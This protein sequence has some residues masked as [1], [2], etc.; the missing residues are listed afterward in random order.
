MLKYDIRSGVK[1]IKTKTIMT[2]SGAAVG[3][4]GLVV[5]IAMPLAVKAAPPAFQ[6]QP[7]EFVGVAGD[8][9]PAPGVD[10]VTAKWDNTTGNPTP[11]ILLQKLGAT[12]NCAAAGV[13]IITPLEGGPVGALT[14]LNFDY[15]DGGHCGAGAPRFD[16]QTDTGTAQALGCNTVLG[17]RTP[18][19]TTGWTHVEFNATDIAASLATWAPGATTL[20]DLYII[21]DEGS[22]TGPDFTGTI[23]IDNISVN[24]QV[25][26]S[27]TSPLT[28]DDC[29]NGGWQNTNFS[30]AFKN[31]GQCVSWVEHNVNGH[32][33]PHVH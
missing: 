7:F 21:F 8:C 9:G 26:G 18:I 24:N 31:Q 32:G 17:T 22:D 11:S 27:P 23:N 19:G 13:D 6:L 5:A 3:I 10:T 4:T 16:I 20:E 33:Q 30:P 15:K 28:K 2:I 29:K 14:E 1:K 25:V 12:S